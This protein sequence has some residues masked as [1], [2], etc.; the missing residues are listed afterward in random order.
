MG[1]VKLVLSA[2]VVDLDHCRVEGGAALT[3]KEVELLRY[4]ADRPGQ[5]VSRE[6]LLEQVWG[7]RPGVVSRTIDTTVRRLR[8]KIERD[9]RKPEA[10]HTMVGEGYRLVLE[11]RDEAE[12]PAAVAGDVVVATADGLRFLAD[13][14]TA[15]RQA[16]GQAAGVSLRKETLA[17]QLARAA[18]PG[19]VLMGA[20]VWD[21]VAL[22]SDALPGQVRHLGMIRLTPRGAPVAVVQLAEEGAVLPRPGL[23]PL[24]SA[25][26]P[27]DELV[28]RGS[29]FQQ[30]QEGL[31]RPGLVTLH[32]E[33]VPL[34][35]RPARPSP[36]YGRG[37]R[38][39][40]R[41]RRPVTHPTTPSTGCRG[42]QPAG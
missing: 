32:G 5:V 31:S 4:L 15:L 16:F 24:Q 34:R 1:G 25:P 9:P 14:M 38:H 19:Q 3:G 12:A 11:E 33:R 36:A 23:S 39:R 10:L 41:G 18:S 28:G 22:F 42:P 17:R 27:I 30:A 6:E 29:E 2:V 13:P 8:K 35:K 40:H 7:Y 21:E 37:D 20:E 26:R